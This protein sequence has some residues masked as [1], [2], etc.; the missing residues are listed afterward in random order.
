M[1][2]VFPQ[3]SIVDAQVTRPNI[4]MTKAYDQWWTSVLPNLVNEREQGTDINPFHAG[5]WD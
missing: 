1:P 5:Y 2:A 3:P 4:I